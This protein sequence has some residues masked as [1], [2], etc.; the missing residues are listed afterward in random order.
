MSDN[1]TVVYGGHV[2]YRRDYIHGSNFPTRDE[3]ATTQHDVDDCGD[4]HCEGA[5]DCLGI[6]GRVM[7]AED[8]TVRTRP[9]IIED[10]SGVLR[11]SLEDMLFTLRGTTR[12][13]VAANVGSDRRDVLS[14]AVC[15]FRMTLKD[16][17]GVAV[18]SRDTENLQRTGGIIRF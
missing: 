14:D 18:D 5:N 8:V 11:E 15:R 17:Q 7:G 3:L 12:V 13:F 6:V 1:V 4:T 2:F 9:R 10:G 16:S